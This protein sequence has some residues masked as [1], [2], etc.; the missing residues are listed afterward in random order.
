MF[1]A[2][3]YPAAL[4]TILP[5][6][7]AVQGVRGGHKSTLVAIIHSDIPP[8]ILLEQI[9]KTARCNWL[10]RGFRVQLLNVT[11]LRREWQRDFAC[12]HKQSQ[13]KASQKDWSGGISDKFPL[14]MWHGL[15]CLT[16]AGE[17]TRAVVDIVS[18]FL[19]CES[20]H[21]CAVRHLDV[22]VLCDT[23]DEKDP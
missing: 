9:L 18:R 23:S 6:S 22:I 12:M 10:G 21:I 8:E 7:T 13:I 19:S 2:G 1:L 5:E 17:R 20:E 11:L 16:R 14:A 3:C 15:V 4:E